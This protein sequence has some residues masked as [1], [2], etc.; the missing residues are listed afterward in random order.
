MKKQFFTALFILLSTLSYGQQ[1]SRLQFSPALPAAGKEVTLSY[2]SVSSNLEFSDA[3][4]AAL[5]IYRDFEWQIDSITLQQAKGR[6]TGKYILPANAAFMAVKFFQGNLEH[7]EAQDNREGQGFY[8]QVVSAKG[9]KVPGSALAEAAVLTPEY[10][11]SRL[12]LFTQPANNAIKVIELLKKEQQIPGSNLRNYLQDYLDLEKRNLPEAEFKTLA[13]N[14][15]SKVLQNKDLTEDELAAVNRAYQVFL[16]D[17]ENAGKVAARLK[18][19]YPNG[20]QARFLAFQQASG[21]QNPAAAQKASLQFL[22][23][24][25]ISEWRKKPDG[26]GFIYYATYRGI[27]SYYFDKKDYENFG[28]MFS[29]LD[30]KTANEVYRWNVMKA[31]MMKLAEPKILFA[32]S[33][34]IIPHLLERQQDGSYH[35]D[36]NIK[37]EAQKNADEQMDNRL[38]THIFLADAVGAY[39]EGKDYFPKLSAKGLYGNAELNEIHLHI[40]EKLNDEKNIVPLLEMSVKSNAVTPVMFAKLKAQYNKG[41]NGSEKGYEKYLASL[42]SPEE[43]ATLL[44]HVQENMVNHP[45]IPFTL[46]D[47]DGNMVSSSSWKDKIVVLDFWATWCRPCIMAFPGMQLL[48]DKYA[49]DPLVAV[50]MIGTMQFGDYK[51]KS[52]NYVRESGFRFNLLHDAVSENGEQNKVFRSLVPL[53]NSSGIPRK[54]IVKNGIVRYSSEGYSGSPSLLMDEL[55]MAIEVLRAEK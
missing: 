13:T 8:T 11:G 40:L 52:V 41:N 45:L 42:K 39:Q 12:R 10:G 36:F 7:P 49:K 5:L 22:K 27:G 47:A 31:A 46:E 23:D 48:I 2:Q 50:Y 51:T 9:K 54:I 25:P 43:T 37:E 29:D 1:Q 24:F 34:K 30:F 3:V 32:L 16:Q 17:K 55:S 4:K 35:E 15:L 19:T 53:F 21:E 26:K 38:F 20:G 44:K 14:S 6:W 28:A 18:S 33:Q